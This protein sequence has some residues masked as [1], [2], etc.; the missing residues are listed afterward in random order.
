MSSWDQACH[1]FESLSTCMHGPGANPTE[2]KA[3]SLQLK[4]DRRRHGQEEQT[5]PIKRLLFMQ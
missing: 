5:L 2:A 4:Q 3:T 1:E